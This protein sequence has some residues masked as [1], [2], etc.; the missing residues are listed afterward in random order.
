MDRPPSLR[1]SAVRQPV[2]L[3][4]GSA[5]GNSPSMAPFS[6]PLALVSILALSLMLPPAR[7]GLAE[8]PGVQFEARLPLFGRHRDADSTFVT[9][10][11]RN[12]GPDVEATAW[13]FVPNG[14]NA[15]TR[16]MSLPAG[17]KRRFVLPLQSGVPIE[18]VLIQVRARADGEER[19]LWSTELRVPES[20]VAGRIVVA[21]GSAATVALRPLLTEPV[22]TRAVPAGALPE[23]ADDYA[24][25][26]AVLL[27]GPPVGSLSERQAQA[28]GTWVRF[29]GHLVFL[30]QPGW[31]PD[32]SLS[33]HLG[34]PVT[35]RGQCELSGSEVL[36]ALAAGSGFGA[37][38]GG[39]FY[40]AEVEPAPSASVLIEAPGHPLVVTR[41][42]GFGRVTWI[43][44]DLSNPQLACWLGLVPLWRRVLELSTTSSRAFLRAGD[45][46]ANGLCATLARDLPMEGLSPMALNECH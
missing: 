26:H 42:L 43:G 8:D 2:L 32:R 44:L 22:D 3:R 15:T 35:L 20:A 7:P 10:D 27:S 24:A 45:S 40:A 19:V 31:G 36:K 12:A 25:V 9:L 18:R 5:S 33:M 41:A 46:Y 34:P 23:D 38:E 29:G 17:S 6:H 1:V 39:P 37:L 30:W 4:S 16:P 13:A 21:Y 14:S 28:L 11:A